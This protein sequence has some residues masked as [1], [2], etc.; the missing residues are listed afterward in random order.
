MKSPKKIYKQCSKCWYGFVHTYKVS[1][2][3]SDLSTSE[4]TRKSTGL[5]EG[6]AGAAQG[7]ST[8]VPTSV[9]Q[10][11]LQPAEAAVKKSTEPV[12]TRGLG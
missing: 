4:P 6:A 1:Y 5:Q 3:A 9:L 2:G 12:A 10:P 11:L 8:A 7:G